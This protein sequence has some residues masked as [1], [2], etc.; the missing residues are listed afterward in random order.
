[1]S[2]M[3][4]ETKCNDC[5][6]AS[7]IWHYGGYRADCPGCVVRS[8]AACPRHIRRQYYATLT[9]HERAAFIEAVR[10][11]VARVAELRMRS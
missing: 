11:E 7:R 10:A 2:S 6:A 1:M 4:N 8:V 3:Q 5:R 9:E